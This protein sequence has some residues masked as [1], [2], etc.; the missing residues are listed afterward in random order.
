MYSYLHNDCQSGSAC[1]HV[2]V[3][4]RWAS[5]SF[6]LAG[7]TRC[8]SK[9][10]ETVKLRERSISVQPIGEKVKSLKYVKLRVDT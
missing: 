7:F 6:L 3:T 10:L 1:P 2:P 4:C 5:P 8:R 9:N